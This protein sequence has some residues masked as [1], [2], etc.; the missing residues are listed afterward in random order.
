MPLRHWLSDLSPRTSGQL[1]PWT[2]DRHEV[3]AQDAPMDVFASSLLA[4]AGSTTSNRMPGKVLAWRLSLAVAALM[5]IQ[6]ATGLLAPFLYRDTEDWMQAAWFGNDLVTLLFAAPVLIWSLYAA[7]K[8]RPRAELVWY[9]L[10]GYSI[11]NYAFYLF[12]AGLNWFFPIYVLLF[13]LPVMALILALGRLDATHIAKGFTPRKR[14]RWIGGY[15]LFT[16]VGLLVAWTVQWAR[17]MVTGVPPDIGEEGL[18]LVAAMDLSFVVPWF[19]IG[20]VLLLRRRPWGFVV[21]P[22][23]IMKGATYTLVLTASSSVAAWRGIEGAFEQIPIWGAWTLAGFLALWG[24]FD[25]M[26]T[27]TT[28]HRSRK[29]Q[30]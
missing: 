19:L 22:I 4:R 16:G 24:L 25:T 12:G 28:V 7:R 11:Y 20:A 26:Q 3:A 21:A 30:E 8:G 10:L 1:G 29:E 2:L 13:T 17:F 14:V 15:M 23:F 6:S 9:S 18:Q 5:V 27:S